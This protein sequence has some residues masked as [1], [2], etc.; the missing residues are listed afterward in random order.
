VSRLH[1]RSRHLGRRP[2]RICSDEDGL[3]NPRREDFPQYPIRAVDAL[4]LA[5]GTGVPVEASGRRS[6]NTDDEPRG[7]SPCNSRNRRSC[8][9]TAARDARTRPAKTSQS[10]RAEA[11]MTIRQPRQDDRTHISDQRYPH[12]A[13]Y[14][15]DPSSVSSQCRQP[16]STSVSH[17]SHSGVVLQRFS[18]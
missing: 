8:P 17:R 6:R 4:A 16:G 5:A 14:T 1:T 10:G 13:A 12:D 15:L 7:I 2:T 18:N 3:G 9:T 11:H